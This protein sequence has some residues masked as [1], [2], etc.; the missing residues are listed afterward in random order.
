[1]NE[2]RTLQYGKLLQ[3]FNGKCLSENQGQSFCTVYLSAVDTQEVYVLVIWDECYKALSN[4]YFN[5]KP[6]CR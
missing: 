2:L 1:M 5:K 3:E 6:S 4:E